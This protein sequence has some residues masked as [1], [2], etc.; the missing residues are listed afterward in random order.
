MFQR[1]IYISV[2]L[3]C[4]LVLASTATWCADFTIY[5]S[6]LTRGHLERCGCAARQTGGM[7]A[8]A[9]FLAQEPVQ[10][11][12]PASNTRSRGRDRRRAISTG[13]A[14]HLLFDTGRFLNSGRDDIDWAINETMVK[15]MSSLGYAAVTLGHEE[16]RT[17]LDKLIPLL[18]TASFPILAANLKMTG[19]GSAPWK[20]FMVLERGGK[21]IAVVGIVP[22]LTQAS[23]L[24]KGLEVEPFSKWTPE[25]LERLIGQEVDFIVLLTQESPRSMETWLTKA[26]SIETPILA[27]TPQWSPNCKQVDVHCIVGIRS[28]GKYLAKVEVDLEQYNP[29]AT[30][31]LVPLVPETYKDAGMH[32][33]LDDFYK[34]SAAG[35]LAPKKKPAL[36]D[37]AD[38][39]RANDGYV[40]AE[41]CKDCHQEAYATWA[42]TP[43]KKAFLTLLGNQRYFVPD[44]VN[45]HTTG[46]GHEE[47]FERF[48]ST[49]NLVGVQCETCHGPG[50][51]HSADPK[52][53]KLRVKIGKELCVQCHDRENSPS[54]EARFEDAWK[55][56]Q[57][58]SNKL[59]VP[60]P[61][62]IAV[63][64]EPDLAPG[65]DNETGT[66]VPS[67]RRRGNRNRRVDETS[68]AQPSLRSARDRVRS[69]RS[70]AET[71]SAIPSLM[72]NE[73]AVARPSLRTARD[74]GRRSRGGETAT[75]RP[76]IRT[77]RD[78]ARR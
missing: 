5:A 15:S 14:G 19:G 52:K 27:F 3:S 42:R 73:T 68:T 24:A 25:R 48:S 65:L 10:T 6:G 30:A 35:D 63:A 69:I 50:K 57:H 66:A 77:R 22:A 49:E 36:M 56:V 9:G 13:P 61:A 58:A 53:A 21:K 2:V 38:E 7:E 62:I 23:K 17:P 40:G 44:C 39:K 70:G 76:S 16:L 59:T 34:Q 31:R 33:L 37:L 47:G 74:R 72:G 4:L 45:C 8:R 64:D 41:G 54:F 32:Q 55:K 78:R 12:A 18:E 11:Q 60:R 20:E 1:G 28:Q 26:A 43:H 51:L 29:V 67:I 71:A 75:A 46:Y